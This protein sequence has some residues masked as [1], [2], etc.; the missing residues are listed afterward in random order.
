MWA[1]PRGATIAPVSNQEQLDQELEAIYDALDR[2]DARAALDRTVQVLA[3]EDDPV[4]RLL[5]GVALLE[6]ERPA[7]AERHLRR[8]VEMDGEDA[9][10]RIKLASS[11]HALCRIDEAREQ[12][13]KGLEIEASLA[14]GHDVM[15]MILELG[16]E[17]AE[18]DFHLTRAAELDPEMFPAPQRMSGEEFE[19]VVREA[20]EAL[21]ET[22]RRHLDD[23][24]LSVEP[25]PPR[26]LL[27]AE[28]PPLD[29]RLLGLFVGHAL[30][31][32]SS[33]SPGGELP[34]RIYLFQRNLERFA[35]NRDELR[36]QIAITVY[37]ELGHYLG[38]DEDE[39]EQI[40]LA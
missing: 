39:L 2:G 32:R 10:A 11:L 14:E 37:H 34:A 15:A 5:A 38:L 22:F 16:G 28:N 9:E 6:L 17:I 3:Q 7:E 40:N 31:E 18:A 8:A 33:M 36:E 4:L 27:E 19:Q 21:P 1:A 30:D 26:T 35:T 24:A 13:E 23:V 25:V 20:G 12:A 29:P